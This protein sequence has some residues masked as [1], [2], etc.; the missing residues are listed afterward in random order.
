MLLS[1]A[2]EREYSDNLLDNVLTYLYACDFGVA[3]F[4]R[5]ESDEFNPNVT[6]RLVICL[7]VGSKCVY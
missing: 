7:P 6:W 5:V 4:E 2:D 3:V 1:R